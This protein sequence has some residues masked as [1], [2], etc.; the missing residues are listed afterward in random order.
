MIAITENIRVKGTY[1]RTSWQRCAITGMKVRSGPLSSWPDDL[2]LPAA[3][4][5]TTTHLTKQTQIT[6]IERGET[7]REKAEGTQGGHMERGW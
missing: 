5:G 6:K 1:L 4:Q 3:A 2:G 7:K